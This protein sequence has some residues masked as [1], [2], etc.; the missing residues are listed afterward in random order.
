MF[1]AAASSQQTHVFVVAK[2]REKHMYRLYIK[3]QGTVYLHTS[4]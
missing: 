2:T 1:N 3:D 4:S